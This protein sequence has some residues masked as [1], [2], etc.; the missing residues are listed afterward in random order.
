MDGLYAR[1]R[2]SSW[3]MPK[4][5]SSYATAERLEP[6]GDK[7]HLGR[8]EFALEGRSFPRPDFSRE[9]ERGATTLCWVR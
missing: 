5:R 4:Q 2:H 9:V 3:L 7:F 1:R 8:S 6:V